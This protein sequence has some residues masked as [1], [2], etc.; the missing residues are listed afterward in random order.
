[1]NLDK[2]SAMQT[3]VFSSMV[4]N[5]TI[6][7]NFSKKLKD[8][9][10]KFGTAT[11]MA[12]LLLSSPVS[13]ADDNG[14]RI[15][16]GTSA[17]SGFMAN[18]VGTEGLPPECRGISGVSGFK[19]GGSMAAGSYIGNHIGGGNGKTLSTVLMGIFGGALALNSEANRIEQSKADCM[20]Q[21]AANQARNNPGFFNH[22]QP[23]S[24]N[25]LYMFPNSNG[26]GNTFVTM[27]N[28]PG[29]SALHGTHDGVK[30]VES[31]P[32]VLNAVN[33]AIEGLQNAYTN[34]QSSSDTYIKLINDSKENTKSA[35][36]AVNAQEIQQGNSIIK[37]NKAKMLNAVKAWDLSY[38][39]YAKERAFTAAIFDNAAIDG[40][41]LSPYSNI[42]N[43]FTPPPNATVA[44]D[45]NIPNRYSSV[46]AVITAGRA[47]IN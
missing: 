31:D 16:L 15:M 23:I 18:N 1:M 38:S 27:D 24:S 11:I 10:V 41:Q 39:N 35:R 44:C 22:N 42:L 12:T 36:Y 45:C 19:V 47:T 21:I 30:S 3:Q 2:L 14:L 33:K 29:L 37:T 34:F 8:N 40:Y 13:H 46:P 6:F 5:E 9:I 28:S 25:V 26:I 7:G 43:L 17:L 20:R 32:E 4:D